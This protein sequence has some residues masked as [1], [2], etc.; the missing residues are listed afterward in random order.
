MNRGSQ[1]SVVAGK[2]WRRFLLVGVL[3][4]ACGLQGCSTSLETFA[5]GMGVGAVGAVAGAVC[6]IGCH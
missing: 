2:M 5:L 6:T 1:Y 4:A 3:S